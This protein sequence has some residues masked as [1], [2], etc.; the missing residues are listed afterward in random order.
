MHWQRRQAKK[1]MMTIAMKLADAGNKIWSSVY[2]G[3]DGNGEIGG[4]SG[5]RKRMKTE[6]REGNGCEDSR[7]NFD[8]LDGECG[9]RV[10]MKGGF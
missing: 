10:A 5:V 1:K 2:I 7:L 4:R 9:K 8:K 6:E 3:G